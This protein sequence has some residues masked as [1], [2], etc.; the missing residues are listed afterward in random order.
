MAV[1]YRP[2]GEQIRLAKQE[3]TAE[4]QALHVAVARQEHARIMATEPRPLKFFRYVDGRE[5]ASEDAVRPYGVI[6]YEYP[7]LDLVA[8]YALQVLREISPLGWPEGGHYRDEHQL[9]IAGSPVGD[10]SGWRP[11]QEVAIVNLM[12]YARVIEVG[13]MRMLVPGTDHVYAQA[14]Q[15][16]RRV[17]ASVASVR[18]EWRAGQP[19]LTIW[20]R[21][22]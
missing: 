14:L 7:R 8:T 13:V 10:L 16:V 3:T 4:L 2:F 12:P 11:G 22:G 5:G 20:E 9:F 18:F 17:Y 21:R 15:R 1:R 19:A 6:R